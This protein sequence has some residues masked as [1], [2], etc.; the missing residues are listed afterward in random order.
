MSERAVARESNGG[1]GNGFCEG[2]SP[3]EMTSLLF[4]GLTQEPFAA[5]LAIS[6]HTL[7]NWEQGRRTPEEPSLARLRI[8]ARHPRVFLK[9]FAPDLSGEAGMI[10]GLGGLHARNAF[11]G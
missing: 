10:L 1:S 8:A 7:R 2:R 5:A 3:V 6:V 11:G 4:I 9:N